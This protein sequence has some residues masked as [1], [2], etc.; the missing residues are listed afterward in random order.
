VDAAVV[1]PLLLFLVLAAALCW[2]LAKV[3]QPSAGRGF[4]IVAVVLIGAAIV[5]LAIQIAPAVG[6]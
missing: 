5:A 3:V 6:S 2:G 1:S 4:N